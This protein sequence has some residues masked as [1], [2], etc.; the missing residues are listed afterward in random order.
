MYPILFH[1]GKFPVRSYGISI[2]VAF[3]AGLWLVRKRAPKFGFDAGKVTDLCFYTLIFGILGARVVFLLQ[4]IGYYSKHLN[5]VFTLEFAGLTSF[6]GLLGGAA[7]VIFW[8]VRHKV[9]LASLLDLLAPAFMLGHVFGRVGCFLNGCCYGRMC[10]AS[11]PLATHFEGVS[12]AHQPAQL[13]DSVMNLVGVGMLLLY[14]RRGFR[15]GQGVG[16]FLILHG[17]TR[18]IYEFWRAGTQQEVNTGIAS[19]TYWPG[20]PITQAQAMALALILAGAVVWFV[21]ARR[22]VA[23]IDPPA[24]EAEKTGTPEMQTA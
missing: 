14:E 1:I 7:Y 8:G 5:E 20:L 10:D 6:G 24:D 22:P 15:P 2:L 12:G 4:D 9:R 3:L 17:L 11:F 19:S 13:Y 16:M 23:P 18:F 21:A